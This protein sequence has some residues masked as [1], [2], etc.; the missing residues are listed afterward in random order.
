MAR[1]FCADRN[2]K[3][4]QI[5]SQDNQ[6]HYNEFT[7]FNMALQ[8]PD[9]TSTANLCNVVE[10]EIHIKDVQH[11]A[12]TSVWTKISVES[13]QHLLEPLPRRIKAT[14]KLYLIKCPVRVTSLLLSVQ[15]KHTRVQH[16]QLHLVNVQLIL[17]FQFLKNVVI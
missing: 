17:S 13:F 16:I 5:S 11:D 10:Q 2:T 8:S 1:L 7:L 12:I 15:H 3:V 6:I 9:L 4:T 14:Q